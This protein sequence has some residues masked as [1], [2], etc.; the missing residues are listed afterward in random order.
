MQVYLESKD[1]KA[2]DNAVKELLKVVD[3]TNVKVLHKNKVHNLRRLIE[4]SSINV[5]VITKLELP[6]TVNI[7]I[8]AQA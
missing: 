7:S 6:E 8:K 2:L 5:S 4:C 1:T 3:C